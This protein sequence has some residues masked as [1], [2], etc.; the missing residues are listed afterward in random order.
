[1]RGSRDSSPTHRACSGPNKKLPP[2]GA[3]ESVDAG[4]VRRPHNLAGECSTLSSLNRRG[5]TK[6]APR[7]S[8]RGAPT[9]GIPPAAYGG[10]APTRP[11]REGCQTRVAPSDQL[12]P[13]G[14]RAPLTSSRRPSPTR[15]SP[16]DTRHPP[17]A[18]RHPPPC[19]THS[20]TLRRGASMRY[21]PV[22][23]VTHRGSAIVGRVMR[24]ACPGA[25][26]ET[27]GGSAA[28]EAGTLARL[29][30]TACLHETK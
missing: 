28:A 17:P 12:R 22:T 30:S 21:A 25:D 20:R 8:L 15:H 2:R 5:V 23:C 18:T 24:F 16:P 4:R 29:Q 26:G 6:V 11:G 3:Q 27:A 7:R 1:V 10:R 14:G 9:S 19:I 13:S